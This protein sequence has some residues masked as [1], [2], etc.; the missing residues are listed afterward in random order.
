MNKTVRTRF[1]P[2]PTGPLHIGGVRTAL[3]N[4]LFAKKHGGQ[5]LLR[6]EDTDK[7]REVEGAI[8]Y[9]IDSFK[10]LGFVPDEG[11]GFGGSRGPYKQSERLDLYK[12][13]AHEL[14]EKGHAYYAFDTPEELDEK[15]NQFKKASVNFIYNNKT[16][17]S[18]NNSL[19]LS[20][21]A[22]KAKLDSGDSYVIRFKM[23]SKTEIKF[24]DK[25]R[26][27]VTFNSETL[28]D[29]VI[30]KSDGYPTYHLANVVDDH[31]M[32]I[33]HV[34]RAEE[35]L[36]S[37]PLHILLYEAFGWEKP[38][39]CHLPLVL[40][41]DGQKLSKRH[42]AKYGFPIFP[43]DWDYVQ[44]GSAAHASGFKDAGFDADALLNFLALLGW[45]PGNNMEFMSMDELISLFDLDRVNKAG[46]V[47]DIEKLKH[48]NAHY[49]R[50]RD[51]IFIFETFIEPNAP[52]DKNIA[53][54]KHDGIYNIIKV[55]QIVDIAKERSI[56]SKDLYGT[57]SYFFEPVVLK[58]D[59]VL[60]NPNEFKE[61][62]ESFF[63]Y[64]VEP[65]DFK[66]ENIKS[67]LE[68]ISSNNGYKIG[69]VLPDLRMA[70]TGGIPGPHLHEVM[71][72]LGIHESLKRI[73]NLIEKTEK[74]PS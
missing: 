42:A 73:K 20:A 65:F 43:L 7:T 60:K 51:P 41:P 16:R 58:D 9:V 67:L 72:I 53:D 39:F 5:F 1:A 74:V 12:K 50:G 36:S 45:N 25:I 2:S 13:Y 61:V 64:L 48:F 19:S 3:F 23:P 17:L 37:T 62:M 40:G 15:R 8:Q 21:D 35:W 49:L 46:A 24:N 68:E 59:V 44:D 71:E 29:K 69:K 4:Y 34:I 31:L 22:V 27:W 56:F 32:A 33:T 63:D 30:F 10:W 52:R 11:P 28:D 47:F 70:L 38:E 54:I 14:I 18:M 66:S 55:G 26:G 57:V 6:I